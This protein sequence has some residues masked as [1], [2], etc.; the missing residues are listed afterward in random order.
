MKP[1]RPTTTDRRLSLQLGFTLLEVLV[2]FVLL[3]LVLG[4][5]LQI[6]SSG[7]RNVSA[8]KHYARAAIIAD[9]KLAMVGTLVPLEEGE[10]TGAEGEY[11][12]R[13]IIKPHHEEEQSSRP[14]Y[15]SYQLYSVVIQ[16]HWQQGVHEPELQF[17]TYRLGASNEL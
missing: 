8:A 17:S 11:T 13:I 12:W 16:L 3:S 15:T 10:S 2:A 9:S 6:F 5:I 7:L 1:N 4:V 14:A